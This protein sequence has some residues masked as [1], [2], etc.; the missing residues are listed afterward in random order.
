MPEKDPS[1]YSLMTY[2]VFAG[3][4]VWGGLVTHIQHIRRHNKPFLWREAIMQIV[5][6]GF[7]GMLTSWLCWYMSAPIPLAGFMAGT[8]GFMGSRALEL[9][10]KRFSK[11]VE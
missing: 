4:A 11:F 2:L 9:F 1:N 6:S 8:A 10:E 3:A 5:I 7:A